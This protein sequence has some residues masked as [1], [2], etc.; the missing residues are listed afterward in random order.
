ME[1]HRKKLIK[2]AAVFDGHSSG[3]VQG[4]KIVIEDDIV[5]EITA[6]EVSEENFDEVFDGT[7]MVAM[8]GMTDAHVHMGCLFAKGE[9]PV[10]YATVLTVAKCKDALMAGFTT[11]R[12]AGSVSEGLKL[13]FDEGVLPGPR[14]YPC[15]AYIS[16]TC[17]HRDSEYAHTYRDIQYRHPSSTVLADGVP[18][19]IRAVREQFYRGASHIKLMATEILNRHEDIRLL[20]GTD[21]MI[22]GP[23]YQVEQSEDIRYYEKRFGTMRALRALTGTANEVFAL[24]TYQNPYPKGK[25]GVL[26]AGSYADLLLVDGDPTKSVSVLADTDHLRLIMKGGTVYK[27]TLC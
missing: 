27:N 12:D 18:E 4:K 7:G 16:Q 17:G 2:N 22:T 20:F 1:K 15:G 13:A 9:F 5:T 26:E 8:P 6:D 14:I 11:F 21:M 25:I 24:T 10:D 23:D 3:L 19:I